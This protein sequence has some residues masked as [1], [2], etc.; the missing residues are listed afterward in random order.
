[1]RPQISVNVSPRQLRRV[2]FL[3][4]VREHLR[5]SGAD[6]ARITVELTE[7]A[8]LQDHADAEPILRELHDLGPPARARRLRLGLLVALAAARDADGDAQD[9]PRV[10]ARGAREPRGVGDRHR[11]PAPGPRARAGRRRRGRRDRGAAA[12]PRGAAV[13]ARPGL[14]ARAPDA[15]RRAGGAHGR[16]ARAAPREDCPA[17]R[18]VARDGAQRAEGGEAPRGRAGGGARPRR[19]R[20]PRCSPPVRGAARSTC[21]RGRSRRSSRS[22]GGWSWPGRACAPGSTCAATA[23]PRR[24]PG[25]SGAG[26][27]RRRTRE[28]PY[29]ALRRVLGQSDERRAVAP[30]PRGVRAP[31]RHARL[32]QRPEARGVVHHLEVADLVLHDVVEDLGRGEQQAPVERHPAVRRARRPARALAADRQA[33][34]GGAGA[35]RGGVEPPAD[36]GAARRGGSSAP[37]P[38]AGRR[39]GRAARRRGGARGCGRAAARASASRR[40]RG[41]SPGARPTSAAA[42]ASVRRRRAIHGRELGHRLLRRPLGGALGER[43]RHAPVGVHGHPDAAGAGGAADAVLGDGH[44]RGGSR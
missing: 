13:P 4:R 28:S 6:P 16:P 33:A 21:G 18:R 23:R 3:A 5:A 8:M 24:G 37:G 20:G 39:R 9:R 11:D 25:G 35:L 12:L 14:P 26:S 40:G 22:R 42:P 1:M 36:L 44:R 19:A 29:Q 30:Q 17:W 7:S 32:E 2:D 31:V 27:S 43:H 15:G 38:A 41:R 10:P 34:V